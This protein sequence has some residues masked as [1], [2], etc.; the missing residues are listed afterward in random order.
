MKNNHDKAILDLA[1]QVD[2]FERWLV[3]LPLSLPT[4]DYTDINMALSKLT[5][6]KEELEIAIL[7]DYKKI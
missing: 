2:K 5:Q 6:I 4:F 7:N 3:I 1:E